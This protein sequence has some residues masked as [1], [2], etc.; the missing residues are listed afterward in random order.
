MEKIMNWLADWISFRLIKYYFS[1]FFLIGS[2][3]SCFQK[4]YTTNTRDTTNSATLEKLQAEGKKFIV[5]TPDAAFVLKKPAIN[6]DYLSGI[7]DSLEPKYRNYLNPEADSANRIRGGQRDMV[8]KQ[9]HLYVNNISMANG[10]VSLDIGKITR[11][12]VY[13]MD[14]LATKR[15]RTGSIVGISLVVGVIALMGVYTAST[16]RF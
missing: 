14:K 6:G 10:R 9:V 5:H 3:S 12:D 7:A 15:S 16:I 11:M 4:F 1:L 13:D 2:L 8:L